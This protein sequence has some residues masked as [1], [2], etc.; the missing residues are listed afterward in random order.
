[1]NFVS[2]SYEEQQIFERV[3]DILGSDPEKAGVTVKVLFNFIKRTTPVHIE[4]QNNVQ[5]ILEQ[6][7]YQAADPV[8][9]QELRKLWHILLEVAQEEE[10]GRTYTTGQLAKF[11]GVSITTINNWIS[12][13]RF[14]G[15]ERPERNKQVRISENT[16]WMSPTNETISIRNIIETYEQNQKNLKLKDEYEDNLERIRYIVNTIDFFEKR[17]GGPFQQVVETKGNPEDSDDWIWAREG[18]E[19]RFL[20]KEIGDLGS[21][22]IPPIWNC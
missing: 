16:L 11:F 7:Q 20:L 10:V 18:K 6:R 17:Y 4:L 1:M 22:T 15:V 21:A 9:Y 5:V 8:I 14:L 19:W 3:A 13:G 12:A 2:I